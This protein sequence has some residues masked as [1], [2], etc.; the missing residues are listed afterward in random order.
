MNPEMIPINSPVGESACNGR[1]ENSVRRVQEKMRALRHQLEHCIGEALPDQLPIMAW[2]AR[3]AAKLISKYFPGDDGKLLYERIRQEQCMVPLANFGEV[4]MYLTMKS[5][6]EN[7]GTPARK[8]GIWLGVIERTE[9]IIIGTKYGVVKCRTVSRLSEMDQWNKEMVLQMRGTP[10]EPVPG[11]Q[12]MHIFVEVDDDG[13]D[14][15]GDHGCDVRPTEILDDEVPVETRGSIDKLHISRKA[16]TR[17]GVTAGCPGCNELIRRGSRPGKINYHHSDE[18][19]KRLIEH[20]EEDPSYRRLLER[21][22]FT[23]DMVQSEILT[24]PQI[25]EKRALIRNAVY[26]IQRKERQRQRGSKEGHLNQTMRDLMCEQMEV[27]EVYSPPRIVEMVWKMGLRVG[28]GLDLI[29]YDEEGRPWDFNNKHMRNAAIRKVIQDKPVLLI[30][31]PMCAPFSA[32]ININYSKMTEEKNNQ[33]EY[34][35][36]R[37]EFCMRL[38]ELQ[39]REERY[40][41]HEHPQAASSWKEECVRKMLR[42]QGVVKVTGDQCRFGL[43]SNDGHKEGLARKRTSFMT[44]SPCIANKLNRRCPNEKGQQVHEHVIL[45]NGRAKAAEIYPPV[46]CRAVCEGL[47]GQLGADRMGQFLIANVNTD[48]N[49]DTRKIMEEAK[50]LQKQ[51]QTVEEDDQPQMEMVWDDVSGAELDPKVV[52]K[53]REEEIEYV[54]KMKLYTKVPIQECY[55]KIGRAP[56]TIRWIDINKGD[57]VNPNCRSRL[58]AREINTHKRDDLFAGTP[59]LEALTIILSIVASGNKGEVV[60]VNDVSRAFFHAK[61]RREV[62]VQLANEDQ[63]L[64]DEHKCGKLSYSMYGTRDAAQNWASE[65]ADMLVSIGF[66]QGRASLCVFFHEQ[67]GIRTFVHGDD[68]VSAAM[69]K[70][71]EWLKAQL[72]GKYQI[73]TQWFGQGEQRSR[74]VKY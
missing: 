20:I 70:Q 23:L 56:I 9:E 67:R 12:N 41:L 34:G 11:K 55:A 58:V 37:L 74:E 65:Y 26:E 30:G 15:E 27:V 33:M 64:G 39:W 18:C 61:A 17:Y 8:F 22:G 19:R 38:Y 13:E 66:T 25:Q 71:L 14:P 46:L 59:L 69:P 10:W 29:T 73:K 48:G 49:I 47:V 32:M 4:V 16:I 2:M 60:M 35:R 36:R 3:W 44:N 62:Y 63:L 50:K 24:E 1:V 42:R 28:W 53:A 7:K 40:F 31:G 57:N 21:H 54:R 5:A 51:Y 52:R 45:I 68:Y 72:E 43:K 6:R